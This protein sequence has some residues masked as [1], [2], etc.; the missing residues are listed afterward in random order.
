MNCALRAVEPEDVDRLYRWEN[1]PENW[2]TSVNLAP[3]SRFQLWEYANSYDANPFSA[4]QLTL[5]IAA[6]DDETAVGYVELYDVSAPH[7]RGMAGIYI[8][9]EFRGKGYGTTAL[10]KL[11]IYCRDSLHF[12]VLGAE[13]ASDNLSAINLFKKAGFVETARRPRWFVRGDA[14]VDALLFQREEV[15]NNK[16]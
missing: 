5:I 2:L 8:A 3:M 9:P 16:G 6:G 4:K 7:G 10:E 13:V 14:A 11:W 12:R 15:G 1:D